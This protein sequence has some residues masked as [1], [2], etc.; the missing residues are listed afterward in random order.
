MKSSAEGFLEYYR[1]REKR[2]D[3][4]TEGFVCI[5]FTYSA[6]IDGSTLCLSVKDSGAGFDYESR[7]GQELPTTGYSGRGIAL[8]ERLCKSVQYFGCGNKVEVVFAW[9]NDD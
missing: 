6:T 3:E 5:H 1:E 7:R 2:L 4:V 9:V 8:I